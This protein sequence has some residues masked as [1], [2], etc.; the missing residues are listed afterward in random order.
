MSEVKIKFC[1]KC[2]ELRGVE[3]PTPLIQCEDRDFCLK[4][5]VCEFHCF[6]QFGMCTECLQFIQDPANDKKLSEW[7]KSHEKASGK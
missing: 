7:E 2:T 1:N 4:E 3:I 5:W 6:E